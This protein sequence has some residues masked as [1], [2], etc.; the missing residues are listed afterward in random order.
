MDFSKAIQKIFKNID[1]R[2]GE[3]IS[4]NYTFKAY[5]S[6]YFKCVY[7]REIYNNFMGYLGNSEPQ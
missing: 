1:L 2:R 5:L 4:N 3:I 7:G 6:S